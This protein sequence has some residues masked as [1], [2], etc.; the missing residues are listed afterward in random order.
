MQRSAFCVFAMIQRIAK[1]FQRDTDPIAIRSLV[2]RVMLSANRNKN[3]MQDAGSV[4][5]EFQYA[6]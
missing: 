5:K 2:Q 3:Q 4:Y 1:M 6:T